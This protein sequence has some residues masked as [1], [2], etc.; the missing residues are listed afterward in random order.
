MI[1][2]NTDNPSQN[3]S[4]SCC[5]Q[6]NGNLYN[7]VICMTLCKKR[8]RQ[9]NKQTNKRSANKKPSREKAAG[10]EVESN[11]RWH[12]QSELIQPEDKRIKTDK[13]SSNAADTFTSDTNTETAFI[14]WHLIICWYFTICIN[15]ECH[16]VIRLSTHPSS[17]HPPDFLP[18]PLLSFINP[19][20]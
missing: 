6:M 15:P 19:L 8:Q 18:L 4:W 13:R 16:P 1:K 11:S 2:T 20:S 10:D 14:C 3:D 9:T 5:E 7:C 17:I 12:F